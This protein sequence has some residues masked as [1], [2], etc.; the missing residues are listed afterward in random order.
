MSSV[1]V[2]TRGDLD[3]IVAFAG[4]SLDEKPGS[5]WVE[6]AGSLPDYICRI[7]RAIKKTGKTTSQAISI[8]V[9]RVKVWATGKGVDAKTQAKATAAVAQWEKLKAKNKAKT[10]AKVA[11]SNTHDVLCLTA[12]YN[13]DTV[14]SAFNAR[15]REARK[16][17][18]TA[19]PGAAYD[20]P[21]GPSDFWVKEIWSTFLIVQSDYGSD[22]D[23]YKIPYTVDDNADVTFGDPVEVKT[24]Y[25][26]VNA[27][28]DPGSDITDEALQKLMDLTGSCPQSPL[29]KVLALTPRLTPLERVLKLAAE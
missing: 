26:V 8:A 27:E 16:A 20:D 4:C 15:T 11:A 1:V 7:A 22:P 6:K 24:E 12:D 17:W 10:A 23:L 28:D 29:D 14:R 5:N 18:R 21:G 9:S 13:M 25:V 19:H 2:F 3:L